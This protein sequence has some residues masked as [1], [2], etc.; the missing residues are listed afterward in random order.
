MLFWFEQRKEL[1][2]MDPRGNEQKLSNEIP[3][4]LTMQN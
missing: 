4:E 2:G 3:N 1:N